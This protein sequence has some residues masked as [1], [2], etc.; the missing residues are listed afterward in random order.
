M[1]NAIVQ[2]L[3]PTSNGSHNSTVPTGPAAQKDQWIGY[4]CVAIAVLMFGSNFVPVKKFKTGDGVFFQ[5]IL[6]CAIWI[7]GF[8]VNVARGFPPFKPFAMLGGFLWCTGNMTTVPIIQT[9]GLG[10]GLLLWGMSN[11]A[12]GWLTGT[13]GFFGIHKQPVNLPWLNY[14][15][16]ALA[17]VAT[18]IFAFIK[19]SDNSAPK[20]RDYGSK[21]GIINSVSADDEDKP[22]LTN[23]N[24][25]NAEADSSEGENSIF[26]RLPPLWKRIL[27]VSLSIF[28]GILYGS[29]F[30]PPQW[31]MDN[32]PWDSQDGLDYVFSHFTGIWLTSTLYFLIYCAFMKNKP[33][34][35][36]KVI[37]PA[38]VSG[39]MW[40]MA[41]ISWFVANSRLSFVIS[42]PL[43]S[44]GPG[45]IG[46]L[47][48]VFVFAEIRGIRNYI[49]LGSAVF[50]TI[51]SAICIALSKQQGL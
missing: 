31:L 37:L 8:V 7:A 49:V 36:P 13:F 12:M 30:D 28:A 1:L 48:G 2:A 32:H 3:A 33:L 39:A 46:S 22:F 38:I 20:T 15:G 10:L 25:Y 27:G 29:N 21:N 19:P 5:W 16:F 35:F 45:I 18:G 42:F 43:I 24:G 51:I 11:L 9:I 6:C 40:A 34:I 41:D 17:I 47:W 44:T 14:V 23:G 50:V 4:I 26:T